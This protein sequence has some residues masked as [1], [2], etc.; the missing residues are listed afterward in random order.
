MSN[1]RGA[2]CR[3]KSYQVL[4][5]YDVYEYRTTQYDPQLGRPLYGEYKYI[6]QIE[7]R[8]QWLPCVGSIPQDEDRDIETFFETEGVQLDRAAIQPNADKRGIAKL[9]LNS[10]CSKLTE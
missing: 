4:Q 5:A 9:C 6:F 10:M 2:N 8:G 3:E 7:G 1:G